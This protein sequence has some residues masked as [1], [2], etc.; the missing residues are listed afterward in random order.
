ADKPSG[1]HHHAN[2][3]KHDTTIVASVLD[4]V[5]TA[6]GQMRFLNHCSLSY[7]PT[8]NSWAT[9][10]VEDWHC[11]EEALKDR[12]DMHIVEY[13][14][15][16][17]DTMAETLGEW[18]TGASDDVLKRKKRARLRRVSWWTAEHTG[19]RG[20]SRRKRRLFQAARRDQVDALHL[21]RRGEGD[22]GGTLA[23]I[24]Q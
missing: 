16:R 19:L 4:V 1:R 20:A 13:N 11:Y 23:S 9:R 17:V 21:A 10:Y 5:P 6:Q 18:I 15:L 2:Q 3:E 12:A 24:C 8:I 22:E 7:L 14:D